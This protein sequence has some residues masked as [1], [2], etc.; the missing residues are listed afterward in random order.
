MVLDEEDCWVSRDGKTNRR[1]R[2]NVSLIQ[3]EGQ[4]EAICEKLDFMVQ[5]KTRTLAMAGA[6]DAIYQILG[7]HPRIIYAV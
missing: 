3:H 1:R 2:V 6:R 5:A 4:H 7:E